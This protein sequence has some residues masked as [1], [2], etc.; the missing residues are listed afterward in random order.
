ML[1]PRYAFGYEIIG[2]WVYAIGGGS[3]DE[4]GEVIILNK[5]ERINISKLPTQLG[6]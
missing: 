3:A 4:E 6:K 5:C 2:D 1:T